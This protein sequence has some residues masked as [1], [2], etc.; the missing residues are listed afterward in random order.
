MKG[1]RFIGCVN[2]KIKKYIPIGIGV[3]GVAGLIQEVSADT[4]KR[5]SKDETEIRIWKSSTKDKSG[6]AELR[7]VI[8]DVRSGFNKVKESDKKTVETDSFNL[9]YGIRGGVNV[10]FTN[11]APIGSVSSTGNVKDGKVSRVVNSSLGNVVDTRDTVTEKPED[12]QIVVGTKNERRFVRYKTKPYK[13]VGHGQ[14][15]VAGVTGLVEVWNING[16]E[17]KFE[18]REVTDEVRG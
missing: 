12:K 3:L 15:L 18:V 4:T 13:V 10:T 2:M 1:P 9:T 8:D 14:V 17:V 6:V 11:S 16:E 5:A 7:K